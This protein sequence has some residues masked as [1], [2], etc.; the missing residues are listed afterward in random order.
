[1]L[2]SNDDPPDGKVL[3]SDLQ[4]I[5]WLHHI[6]DFILRAEEHSSVLKLAWPFMHTSAE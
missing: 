1:M 6:K 3:Q 2:P 5:G 4:G